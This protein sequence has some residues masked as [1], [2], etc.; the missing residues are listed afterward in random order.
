[1]AQKPTYKELANRVQ[2]LEQI[3]L[4]RK[5]AEEVLRENEERYQSLSK[6]QRWMCDN[7][8]DMI[9]AKGLDKRYLFVN[10]AICQKLLNAT[11]TDEPLG[12][13]DL[14]FAERE[15]NRYPDNPNWHTFGELCQ[16]SDTIT[17]E[18]GTPQQF[19]EFGN[20]KGKYLFLDVH[21]APFIDETGKM[22]GTV[23]SARDVTAA[24]KIEKKLNGLN[25]ELEERIKKRTSSLEDVNTALKVLL[26]KREEDK[27]QIG[28]NIYANFKSLIQ[29]LLNQLKNSLTKNEQKDIL[30]ILES[31][32]KEMTTPFSKKL[33]DPMMGLTPTEIQVAGL[34]K[35][36]KTNKEITQI[37]NKSIRA[38]SSHRENIR[39][40]L[41]LKNKKINLRTYLLSLD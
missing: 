35:D 30:D 41:G 33:S 16:D 28:A 40:K 38:V 37:L 32:I 24:K 19:D 27:N 10:K 12:K 2:V 18:K 6:M 26:K 20:V 7:V 22:I 8:P 25:E 29:P 1:M 39:Q 14:F 31:S 11:D 17:M 5:Q 3:E 36:G 4:N 9:W 34:V 15:R 23:G 21:K 13:T